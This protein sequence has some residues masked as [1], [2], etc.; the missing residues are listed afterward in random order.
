MAIAKEIIDFSND[1]SDSFVENYYKVTDYQRENLKEFYNDSSAVVWNGTPIQ[2]LDSLD[3]LFRSL[4]ITLHEIQ[5]WDC[6]PIQDVS[7]NELSSILL[8]VNGLVS[9]GKQSINEFKDGKTLGKH[10]NKDIALLP[11]TFSQNFVLSRNFNNQWFILCKYR[12]IIAYFI[13]IKALA[14]CF[15]YVG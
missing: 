7:T 15:R 12:E 10:K 9:I 1:T 2:G 4:P 11:K 5:S 3:N 6:H 13:L 8:N 14:D